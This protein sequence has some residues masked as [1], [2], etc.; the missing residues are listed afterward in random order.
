MA[1]QERLRMADESAGD[2]A[3]SEQP[4]PTNPLADAARQPTDDLAAL[5]EQAQSGDHAAFETLVTRFQTPVRLYL[6]HLIDDDEQAR[7]LAQDTFWQA[8]NGLPRLRDPLHFRAW[9]FRVA[10]NRGRSWLRHRRLIGWVSLD[11]LG[12]SKNES[13]YLARDAASSEALHAPESGFEE[14]LIETETL[15]QAL[16]QVP[17]EYRSCLLLHLSLGFT[18]PEVAEQLSLTPGAVRMRL[19][20]GLAALR[21]AYQK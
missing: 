5:V 15:Q 12:S 17:A 16:R 21:K 3:A 18:V 2:D 13:I 7:D 19:F 4:E 14:R 8:W 20:R 6:A 1:Q 11:W 10:T 9:L